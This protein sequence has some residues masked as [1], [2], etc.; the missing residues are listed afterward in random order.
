MHAWNR[1]I[2]ELH[3]F[4]EDLFLGRVES[5]NR[6]EQALDASFTMAGPHGTRT[7]RAEVLSQLEAGYNQTDEL[8]IGIEQPL[9]IADDDKI[10]VA[11]YIEVHELPNGQRN[12]RRST[13]VFRID[14]EGPNGL[15]WLRV[16]ETFID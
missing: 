16:H 5:L 11:E 1:A 7:S 10:I 9:L 15:R 2:V 14:P 8:S 4:F 13:V 12:R 6:A 3:Q